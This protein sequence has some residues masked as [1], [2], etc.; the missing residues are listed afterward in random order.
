MKL[1]ISKGYQPNGLSV[2]RFSAIPT[3]KIKVIIL[4]SGRVV[5]ALEA[6]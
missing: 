2:I 4:R 3:K 6:K 1:K 5:K